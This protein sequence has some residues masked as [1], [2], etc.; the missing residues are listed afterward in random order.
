MSNIVKYPYREKSTNKD[1][2]R[3]Y[4]MSLNKTQITQLYEVFK[5][6]FDLF[7]YNIDWLNY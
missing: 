2:A 7:N 5:V 1:L 6:D 4:Y 3:L